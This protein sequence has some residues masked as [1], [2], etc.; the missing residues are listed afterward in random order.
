MN[1]KRA[2]AISPS[3]RLNEQT[4]GVAAAALALLCDH[5]EAARAHCDAIMSATVTLGAS[6]ESGANG[7]TILRQNRTVSGFVADLRAREL[8]IALRLMQ[9]GVVA[10]RVASLDQ[11]C[12]PIAALV[13]SGTTVLTDAASRVAVERSDTGAFIYLADRGA[14]PTEATILPDEITI[15][16]NFI[17]LGVMPLADVCRFLDRALDTIDALS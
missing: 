2:H 9:A 7:R 5:L 14:L 8:S 10:E 6:V 1:N 12:R 4:H 16:E 13:K 3:A 11:R 15:T 17:V